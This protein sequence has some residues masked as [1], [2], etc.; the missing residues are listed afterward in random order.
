M[1]YTM[2]IKLFILKL[3]LRNQRELEF[4]N[5]VFFVFLKIVFLRILFG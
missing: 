2:I 4:K 3:Y 5:K 1:I